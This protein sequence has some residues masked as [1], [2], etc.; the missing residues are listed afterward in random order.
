MGQSPVRAP[1]R[2][3]QRRRIFTSGNRFEF[4]ETQ[5]PSGMAY[6]W[7]RATLAGQEDPENLILAEQNGWQTVPAGRHPE[8]AGSRVSPESEIR[9]GGL[10]LME[11]PKEYQQES[12]EMDDFAARHAVESQ[13]S[14]LGLQAR[15]EGV[16]QP[17]RRSKETIGGEEI[18]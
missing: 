18:E 17:F 14:R 2:S 10:V 8:L 3:P 11:Q 1:Q 16:K 12:K 6:Q 4:D 15:R 7:V 5:I 13:I 9:R